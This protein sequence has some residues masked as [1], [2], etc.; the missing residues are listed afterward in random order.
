MDETPSAGNTGASKEPVTATSLMAK[1]PLMSLEAARILAM[2]QY[3]YWRAIPTGGWVDA[4]EF[5]EP[6]FLAGPFDG[7]FG[8]VYIEHNPD[9]KPLEQQLRETHD[10]IVTGCSTTY[11]SYSARQ[12]IEQAYPN[13]TLFLWDAVDR[14]GYSELDLP[15]L[16]PIVRERLKRA[17]AERCQVFAET[18]QGKMAL[19]DLLTAG[20]QETYLKAKQHSAAQCQAEMEHTVVCAERPYRVRL[21]G[22]D[23]AS[24]TVNRA[25]KED[26]EALLADLRTLGYQAVSDQMWF[27]N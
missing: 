12:R 18:Q 13:G 19:L 23:D 2:P 20:E 8:L 10:S 25:T 17:D 15:H 3:A 14:V 9:A 16:S 6:E 11:M 1:H 26:V 24:W 21:Q 5:S 22:N 27:T 4:I 7:K